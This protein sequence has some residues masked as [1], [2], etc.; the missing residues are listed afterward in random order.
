MNRLVSKYL[1]SVVK[2]AK[3]AVIKPVNIDFPLPE[4]VEG[5]ENRLNSLNTYQLPDSFIKKHKPVTLVG[6]NVRLAHLL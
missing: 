3:K 5:I 6:Q 4:K 2:K 1:L